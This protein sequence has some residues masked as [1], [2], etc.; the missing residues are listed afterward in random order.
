MVLES[1]SQYL[2]VQLYSL[3]LSGFPFDFLS[4]VLG[5]LVRLSSKDLKQQIFVLFVLDSLLEVLRDFTEHVKFLQPLFPAFGNFS[6]RPEF[7]THKGHVD[8]LFDASILLESLKEATV[9]SVLALDLIEKITAWLD[10]LTVEVR[11]VG[12][13]IHAEFKVEHIVLSLTFFQI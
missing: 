4:W 2:V 7:E 13:F 5:V 6:V 10:G 12:S 1:F 11:A 3:F 8:E 9:L